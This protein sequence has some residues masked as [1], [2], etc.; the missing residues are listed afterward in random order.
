MSLYEQ[1]GGSPAIEAALDRFYEKVMADERM[2][3]YFDGTNLAHLKKRQA[4]FLAMAFGGPNHYQGRDLRTAH[5]AARRQGLDEDVFELFMSRF[6]TT[7]EELG[8]AEEHV[9]DVMTI[10]YSGKEEVLGR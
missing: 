1:L 2:R 10:A 5:A 6:R 8:V 7:L 9:S 4:A 3:P